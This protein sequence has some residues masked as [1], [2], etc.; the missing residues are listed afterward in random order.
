MPNDGYAVVTVSNETHEQITRLAKALEVSRSKAV[1]FAVRQ[2]LGR[3]EKKAA[4]A[5]EIRPC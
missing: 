3:L 2:A 1:R 4:K 5:K